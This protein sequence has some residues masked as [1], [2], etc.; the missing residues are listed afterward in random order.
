MSVGG[1]SPGPKG[2]SPRD[3]LEAHHSMLN[4][5]RSVAQA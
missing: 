5:R 2:A 3:S 4:T 1:R